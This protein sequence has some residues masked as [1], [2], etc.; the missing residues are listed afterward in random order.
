VFEIPL[1]S[2]ARH[3]LVIERRSGGWR[4]SLV[5][6]SGGRRSPLEE[7]LRDHLAIQSGDRAHRFD[8]ERARIEIA[9]SF[10]RIEVRIGRSDPV[11][12]LEIDLLDS[13][14]KVQFQHVLS[15]IESRYLAE[16]DAPLAIP[17]GQ[18]TIET[19]AT[20]LHTHFAGCV[21][22]K[23][24]IDIGLAA[25]VAF[26]SSLLEGIGIHVSTAGARVRLADLSAPMLA[27]LEDQIAI[28]IDRR[29][30]FAEMER[31]YRLRAPIT[32]HEAAFVPQLA[33]IAEDYRAMGVKY[34]ELSL[35]DVVD[36][37][38]LRTIHA[39]LPDIE[40]ASGVELRFLA[41]FSRHDDYE[42]DLDLIDRIRDLAESRYLAG[43]D[44]MG[45]ETN[46]TRAFSRQLESLADLGAL[47]PG[48]VI[49]VHAGENPAHPE[50]VRV[51]IECMRDRDV[52]LRIGHGLYGVDDRTLDALLAIGAIVEFNLNSN[53]ALNNVQNAREVPI[54]RYVRAGVPVVLGTDGYGIYQTTTSLEARAATLFGLSASDFERIRSTEARYLAR[55][56][57]GDA[58]S[59]KPS[60]LFRVPEARPHRFYSPQIA[61]EKAAKAELRDERLADR[62]ASF[63]V[64]RLDDHGV[65]ALLLGKDCISF[66]GA[67]KKSWDL[68]SPPEK[69][70][71]EEVIEALLAALPKTRT[72]LIT[73]GTHYGVEHLVARA[74]SRHG[75]VVLGALVNETPPEAIE[76][77]AMTHACIV[78][79]KLH[80][81]AAGLYRLMKEHDGV[82][83]FIGGGHIV[84]DEIQTALNLRLRFAL[85][86]G[87][88]GAS[89]DHA[90][91]LPERAFVRAEEVLAFMA[92]SRE[93]PREL[94]PFWHVGANPTVD[95]AVF[96][97]NGGA[98]ELLLIQRDIDAPGEGGK[99]A[100]PGGFVRTDSPRGSPWTSGRESEEAACL[101]ELREETALDLRPLSPSMRRLGVY[102]GPGRD[103]R[104]TDTAWSRTTVFVFELP[105]ELARSTIA[106][107]DDAS[108]A[109]WFPIARL[110]SRLAF[111][112]A[113]IIE[114][115]LALVSRDGGRS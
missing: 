83:I 93:R 86:L 7:A 53:F 78:A 107:G 72:V 81:K 17:E 49:R 82:C 61:E 26:P 58:R 52:Q 100:L 9:A 11:R 42:W 92:K 15:P 70:H 34:A 51:A 87:P 71:V 66:A 63:G 22:A 46:S 13:G 84:S 94:V 62:I 41:A 3:R 108:D 88:E 106:G 35:A 5:H 89:T 103:P 39:A 65:A 2:G 18:G 12:I 74:A 40:R 79:E 67:W 102:E 77:G 114:D 33:R 31:I 105:D 64:A 60:D 36:A 50:N 44:F 115:A 19:P 23:E 69:K 111:D 1:D 4:F 38:R 98:R 32:K 48:F 96:R 8:E 101:R 85:M 30:P 109:R 55:R 37:D 110:P 27:K 21:R 97:T 68:V 10:P 43:V 54:A 91:Q 14:P 99:W 28:P 75:L 24:L 76:P 57:A 113:R 29:V 6:G 73:G 80:G 20:D 59:T 25:E 45:H 47:R 104:D 112:H 90:R 95:A 16:N 56:R